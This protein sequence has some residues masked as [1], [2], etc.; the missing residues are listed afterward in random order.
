MNDQIWI[1]LCAYKDNQGGNITHI[2]QSLF[3]QWLALQHANYIFI[4]QLS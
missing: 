1:W 4:R 2:C 3:R